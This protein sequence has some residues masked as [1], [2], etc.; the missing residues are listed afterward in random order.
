VREI[1][2]NPAIP[3]I[4]KYPPLFFGDG[5]PEKNVLFLPPLVLMHI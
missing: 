1:V 2:D 3:G 5:V 4:L